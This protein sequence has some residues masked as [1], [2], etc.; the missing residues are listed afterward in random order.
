MKNKNNKRFER[1]LLERR[2]RMINQ[3]TV[4]A[5]NGTMRTSN[6][7]T[8]VSSKGKNTLFIKRRRRRRLNIRSGMLIGIFGTKDFSDVSEL[9]SMLMK[10]KTR[11]NNQ[12]VCVSNEKRIIIVIVI[13]II[14]SNIVI[15]FILIFFKFDQI[16]LEFFFS[17][18]TLIFLLHIS[19]ITQDFINFTFYNNKRMSDTTFRMKIMVKEVTFNIL[20]FTNSSSIICTFMCHLF[21]KKICEVRS[22]LLNFR[23]RRTEEFNP[24]IIIEGSSSF[25]IFFFI[26]SREIF[27]HVDITT[28]LEE[29]IIIMEIS[30]ETI[31]LT[32]TNDSSSTSLISFVF[33][34]SSTIISIFFTIKFVSTDLFELFLDFEERF[35]TFFFSTS[36]NRNT[37]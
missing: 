22:L 1:E 21:L 36:I 11:R 19:K 20:K 30:K 16:L 15:K 37:I 14:F 4:D 3:T 34:I 7:Q 27:L 18:N 31:F 9:S 5:F 6:F 13:N 2:R 25:I 24:V 12:F 26:H 32:S 8:S 28:I 33:E 29:D 10:K 23:I 17:T 35:L